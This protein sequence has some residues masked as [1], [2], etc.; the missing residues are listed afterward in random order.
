MSYPLTESARQ[1]R[2]LAGIPLS[3]Y[4][5]LS[6]HLKPVHLTAGQVICESGA[7][8]EFVYF[9]TTCTTSLVSHTADGDSS[10]LAMTGRDGM[11]GVSL[12]LGSGSMNHRAVVQCAGQAYRMPA[13]VFQ[14]E[15]T[16]CRELQQLALCYVQSL[17]TQMSQSIVCVA[18][19]SVIERLC[20]W[21]L[22]NQDAVCS[23]QLNVTHETIANMLG[24]RRESITQALGKL[25]S[26]GLVSSGRGKIHIRDRDGLAESVCECFS[27]VCTETRRLYERLERS[28]D[29]AENAHL[30]DMQAGEQDHALLHKYQDAYDFAPVGFV[31][32]DPQGRVVQTNLAGAI[33]LDIQRSQRTLSPL[34]DFIAPADRASFLNF[35]QEV[36][37]G[38]C[39]RYCEVTLCAT[40]HRAEMVVRIDATLDEMGDEC[41]LVMIDVTE[42]KKIAAH[43]LA[44]ERQQQE[45]LAR[46]PFMLWFKDPQ[47]RLVSANA[48]LLEDWQHFAQDAALEKI[49]VQSMPMT[50][51]HPSVSGLMAEA[52]KS[53]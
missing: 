3:H 19:H 43:E 33:M 41:R 18:H 21:L 20:Y 5:R 53:T 38:K 26:A 50:F 12:V 28:P 22:F 4:A 48:S 29:F 10:E 40:S 44:L 23:D 49:D 51:F 16:R 31:S 30:Q 17:I 46:Q 7:S 52:T 36:L 11:V 45:R 15:L 2:I 24:V 35:H 37:S 27:L 9:P 39:R 47:G 1:N 32:L 8:L 34:V 13:D 6:E 42:E 14:A 25:Q